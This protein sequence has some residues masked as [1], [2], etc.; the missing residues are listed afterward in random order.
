MRLSPLTFL[1]QGVPLRASSVNR[2]QTGCGPGLET[3]AGVPYPIADP[4]GDLIAPTMCV[5]ELVTYYSSSQ[6]CNGIRG[7]KKGPNLASNTVIAIFSSQIWSIFLFPINVLRTIL[8]R[9]F[10]APDLDTLEHHCMLVAWKDIR[11]PNTGSDHLS[12]RTPPIGF[13]ASV[14]PRSRA[15]FMRNMEPRSESLSRIVAPSL[16]GL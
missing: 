11:W 12:R 13:R 14:L 9:L 8:V 10:F 5:R 2:V 1:T 15:C 6:R 3:S 4:H 16:S 7:G